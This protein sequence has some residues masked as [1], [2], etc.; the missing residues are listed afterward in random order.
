MDLFN[1]AGKDFVLVV[2]HYSD[3]WEVDLLPDLA[4]DT[5]IQRRKVQFVRYGIPDWVI[6]DDGSQLAYDSPELSQGS[7]ASNTSC[8][9]RD[10]RKPMEKQNLP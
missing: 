7:G 8:H 4:A 3:F 2:D 10:T 9:R 6:T 5:I 1:Q